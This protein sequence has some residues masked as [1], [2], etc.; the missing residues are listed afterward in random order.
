MMLFCIDHKKSI[1]DCLQSSMLAPAVNDAGH[2]W[3]M[4]APRVHEGQEL[5]RSIRTCSSF[6]QCTLS[7]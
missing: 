4:F 7:Q 3:P 1:P 2:V 5:L 6:L